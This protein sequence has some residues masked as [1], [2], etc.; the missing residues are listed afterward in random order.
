MVGT[1]SVSLELVILTQ[2]TTEAQTSWASALPLLLLFL[3]FL[4]LF[5]QHTSRGAL[6]G[7]NRA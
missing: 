1:L 3:L 5:L 4:F 6:R 2:G 7:I